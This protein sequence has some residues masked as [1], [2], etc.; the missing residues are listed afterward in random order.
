MSFLNRPHFRFYGDEYEAK[1]LYMQAWHYL[2]NMKQF[3]SPGLGVQ[4]PFHR[5]F[6]D[7][8]EF[9]VQCIGG[10]DQIEIFVPPQPEEQREGVPWE[11]ETIFPAIFV[12]EAPTDTGLNSRFDASWFEVKN[13]LS[14]NTDGFLFVVFCTVN[15]G[16]IR[17]FS[18]KKEKV[19]VNRDTVEKDVYSYYT[20][21]QKVVILKSLA[22]N[23]NITLEYSYDGVNNFYDSGWSK[24]IPLDDGVS[25][26]FQSYFE[27]WLRK[28]YSGDGSIHTKFCSDSP[29]HPPGYTHY[30]HDRVLTGGTGYFKKFYDEDG[31]LTAA[32]GRSSDYNF[33]YLEDWF[34][35]YLPFSVEFDLWTGLF[36]KFYDPDAYNIGPWEYIDR[37][38]NLEY[39]VGTKEHK[40][41]CVNSERNSKESDY[42]EQYLTL[43]PPDG[44]N[45]EEPIWK[46][47]LSMVTEQESKY[48][49]PD[50]K[51]YH[52]R[53]QTTVTPMLYAEEDYYSDNPDF[54]RA[55]I[56][57][58][59]GVWMACV[60]SYIEDADIVYT[61]E[62]YS[63]SSHAPDFSSDGQITLGTNVK[64]QVYAFKKTSAL[65]FFIGGKKITVDEF[66]SEDSDWKPRYHFVCPYIY[67]NN[68]LGRPIYMYAYYLEKKEFF[69][70]KIKTSIEYIRYGYLDGAEQAE[71]L[72][73]VHY[74]SEKM[75]SAGFI[76]RS[77]IDETLYE[78]ELPYHE[79]PGFTEQTGLYG[80][81][82]CAPVKV[83]EKSV[84]NIY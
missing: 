31:R 54:W 7:G 23:A 2:Q 67:I 19:P 37:C 17:F 62:D 21:N 33:I 83:V 71:N 74:Q 59:P 30:A 36:D 44:T 27:W 84:E 63:H 32:K 81:C 72:E 12:T 41:I 82:L 29:E 57:D 46:S 24:R 52:T 4:G 66:I 16:G 73:D 13:L 70:D 1:T 8:T 22:D 9:L 55:A 5:I 43:Y 49:C 77:M 64:R 61:G 26:K 40:R 18:N 80:C 50:N 3:I 6:D 53:E 75:E 79:I 14:N 45:I 58:D 11:K 68:T 35:N 42:R 60:S 34:A 51:V 15:W 78:L 47:Q 10:V 38:A 25:L 65:T 28:H 56:T 48:S 69:D 39:S 76:N 20:D